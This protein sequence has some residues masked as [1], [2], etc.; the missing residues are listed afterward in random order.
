MKLYYIAIAAISLF[1]LAS[2]FLIPDGLPNQT[3]KKKAVLSGFDAQILSSGRLNQS[4]LKAQHIHADFAVFVGGVQADFKKAEYYGKSAFL[5]TEPD[6]DGSAGKK[7]HMH[8]TNVPLWVFFESI[9][10]RFGRECLYT[11]SNECGD[12]LFFVNGIQNS[13]YENYVFR[14]GDRLLVTLGPNDIGRE[15]ESVTNHSQTR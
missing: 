15:K 8:S 11:S 14:D 10:M 2:L 1:I 3:A 13:E 7:L 4:L 12:V 5:H 9:G 6:D